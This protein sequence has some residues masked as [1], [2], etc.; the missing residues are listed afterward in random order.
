LIDSFI[1]DRGFEPDLAGDD[2]V[3]KHGLRL[4]P[5]VDLSP[6]TELEWNSKFTKSGSTMNGIPRL[7]QECRDNVDYIILLTAD[8]AQ[9]IATTHKVNFINTK[10]VAIREALLKTGQL[11]PISDVIENSPA[12]RFVVYRVNRR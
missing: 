11:S 10:I 3:V 2:G 9:T 8:S 4:L 12:E 7:V 1:Y 6:P 5:R